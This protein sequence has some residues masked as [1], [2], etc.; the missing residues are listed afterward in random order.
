MYAFLIIVYLIVCVSLVAAILMQS[1]KGGGLSESLGGAFQSVFGPKV[2]NV[3]VK[4]TA[5]LATLFLI[6]SLTLAKL[7]TLKSRSLMER[8]EIDSPVQEESQ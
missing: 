5:I 2:S 3:L 7:S 1:G 8:V 6:L 4:A